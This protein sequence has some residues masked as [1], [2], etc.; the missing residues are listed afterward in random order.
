MAKMGAEMKIE[1]CMA[2]VLRIVIGWLVYVY[3]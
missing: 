1:V 3:L 2:T